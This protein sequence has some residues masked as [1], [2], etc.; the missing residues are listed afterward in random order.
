MDKLKWT[1]K[2]NMF[3]WGRVEESRGDGVWGMGYGRRGG[4]GGGV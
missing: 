4:E 3:G 1:P 2:H